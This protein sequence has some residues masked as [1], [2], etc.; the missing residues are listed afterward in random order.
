MVNILIAEDQRWTRKGIIEM[1]DEELLGVGHIHESANGVEAIRQLEAG[2]V[3]ILITDIRMPGIDGLEL[4]RHVM[5]HF[6][7]TKVIVISGHD[8]FRY[9]REALRY[10]VKDYLLK[11][12]QPA[13][14][15]VALEKIVSGHQMDKR[16]EDQYHRMVLRQLLE[17]VDAE[18][19]EPLGE[20]TALYGSGFKRIARI[21]GGTA[22]A[23]EDLVRQCKE[24]LGKGRVRVTGLALDEE[25]CLMFAAE[26][27]GE[28]GGL[29]RLF[30]E[31]T[32]LARHPS[33]QIGI[34]AEYADLGHTWISDLESM[35]A[36]FNQ[37][38]GQVREFARSAASPADE[39]LFRRMRECVKSRDQTG[40]AKSLDDWFGGS[41]SDAEMRRRCYEWARLAL[42]QC[43][44]ESDSLQSHA[45]M[46]RIQYLVRMSPHLS[47]YELVQW[48]R[49]TSRQE[50]RG[51]TPPDE[52]GENKNEQIVAWCQNYIMN[53]LENNLSLSR[54]SEEV[55]FSPGHLSNLFKQ[56]TG[57]T[58]IEYVT[59]LK[60][61]RAKKY[62]EETN[63]KVHDIACSLG[64]ED[65]RY[66]SKLFR[67]EM[68]M[69]PMEYKLK[70]SREKTVWDE[71]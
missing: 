58:F 18:E 38:A 30:A 71:A 21:R 50:M 15:N 26:S 52:D 45:V 32:D 56:V 24:F 36:F 65:A 40:L 22:G 42:G 11:P 17:G 23:R 7:Q 33:L 8:E 1:I 48:V 66:F 62:L 70:A 39:A 2:P 3:D 59:R 54:L 64:Y 67:R 5:E 27:P 69:T 46:K 41:R 10:G 4:S 14:L 61:E 16:R 63:R 68:G 19:A 6:P 35:L 9:A 57:Q 60:I 53:N 20:F 34:S 49:E 51:H 55:H 13:E 29:S 37:E 31:R 43:K 28:L 12:I 44:A 47:A 25:W